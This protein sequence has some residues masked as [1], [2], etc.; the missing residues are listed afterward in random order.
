D[1]DSPARLILALDIAG[2]LPADDRLR[3]TLP[4]PTPQS[5]QCGDR[6]R[7]DPASIAKPSQGL[8][9][10]EQ[11][12]VLMQFS[13]SSTFRKISPATST[14][15]EREIV[16]TPPEVLFADGLQRTAQVWRGGF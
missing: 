13:P 12:H 11:P 9:R 14:S 4:L 10:R 8:V 3:R 6:G 1:D 5:A 16:L 7:L 15:P 2:A